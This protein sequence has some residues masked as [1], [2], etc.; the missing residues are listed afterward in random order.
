MCGILGQVQDRGYIDEESFVKMLTTLSSRGPD[1]R[2]WKMLNDNSVAL[3]H[4]RLAIIDLSEAGRQP[5]VN[6]DGTV[7]LTFN[8]EIYNFRKL[9]ST[10]E[11][12]GHRFSSLTDSE[13]IIHAYEE[14][15]DSFVT[16]LRGIFAFGLWD[17]RLRRLFLA[18]DHIGVKPLYYWSSGKSIVFASQPRA[19]VEMPG[20][21]R[22]IDM[23]AMDAYLAY[24]YIP[25]DKA[26]FSGIKKLPA[27][28]FMVF[29][30]GSSKV[31]RYW[32]LRYNPL[33]S[34]FQ[35]GV[36]A[37][38][39]KLS[40][41]VT[42]QLVSDVPIGVFLSGGV[43]S[44]TVTSLAHEQIKEDLT[45]F[46]IGFDQAWKDERAYARIIANKY[47]T[48]HRERVLSV[49]D[50]KHLLSLF[51][52]IYD[53]PFSDN[54]GLATYFV[55]D[56]TRKNGI[57]VILAGDGGD[58]LFV[59]YRRYDSF[60]EMHGT[61]STWW[62]NVQRLFRSILT[63]SPRRKDTP[64]ESYFGLIGVLS[65]RDRS[66]LLMRKEISRA[67]ELLQPFYLKEYPAV[68]AAQYID[69]H[70]YLVDDILTK[71]DRASMSCGVE[72]RVPLLDYE[73][74]E[75]AFQ[76][77]CGLQ[78]RNNERKALLKSAVRHLLPGEILTT[79]KKGFGVPMSAWMNEGIRETAVR[80]VAEGCLVE[81]GIFS[82]EKIRNILTRKHHVPIWLLFA[83]ELWARRWIEGCDQTALHAAISTGDRQEDICCSGI[84]L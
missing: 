45:T 23:E 78:Y 82:R 50:G 70:T 59:G 32:Q 13:V 26:I 72:V 34:D 77:D 39:E 43:D 29:E 38:R 27:A 33:I 12:L 2:N 42:A 37:I 24:G 40:E 20:F 31:S 84:R 75:L 58:E 73:L 17:S 25:Y 28:H 60:N 1:G 48:I 15:G 5:M 56:F 69:L 64:L 21:R 51:A 4:C 79:R 52:D 16:R 76:M 30:G 55:S 49:K 80:L 71:V 67:T 8:G 41:V 54:S 53:E 3:G 14:W 83:A 19:I 63:S 36:S 65:D 74:V 47:H 61:G 46:T 81:R 7:W 9:R 22:E 66:E 68:T 35:E 11:G 6:E 57:K 44:S 18:R 62:N 10:L